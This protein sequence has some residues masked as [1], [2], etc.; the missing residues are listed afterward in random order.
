MAK[1]IVLTSVAGQYDEALASAAITPGML[2]VLE[3]AGTVKA[4]ATQAGYAERIFARED[5]LQG[6]AV[7]TAYASGARV[8][9]F[10]AAPGDIVNILLKAGETITIGETLVSGGNGTL[11]ASDNTS[12]GVTTKQIIATAL[13]AKNL[14]ASGSVNTLIK[15]RI[16]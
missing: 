7:T 2:L 10:I 3:T 13:E 15:A 9:Y 12:S 14:S 6:A 16:M 11:I 5:S 1:T 4:H 8:P